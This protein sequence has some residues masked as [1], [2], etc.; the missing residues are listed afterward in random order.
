MHSNDASSPAALKLSLAAVGQGII[1]KTREMVRTTKQRREKTEKGAAIDFLPKERN[2]SPMTQSHDTVHAPK[3]SRRRSRM[4]E[5]FGARLL[6]WLWG[7]R[8]PPP[9]PVRFG[10]ASHNLPKVGTPFGPKMAQNGL[11]HQSTYGITSS[12]NSKIVC[13]QFLG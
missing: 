11:S 5:V 4:G 8:Y 1:E 10:F 12:I 9:P 13:P 7:A 6:E 3:N 2:F